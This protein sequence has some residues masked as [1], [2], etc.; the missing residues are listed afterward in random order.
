MFRVRDAAW[1]FAF[2]IMGIFWWA[3]H[4]VTA[5]SLRYCETARDKYQ[6]EMSKWRGRAISAEQALQRKSAD[7][8][9]AE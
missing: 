5:T 9:K 2:V 7:V 4:S 6:E 3:D 8:G 1:L